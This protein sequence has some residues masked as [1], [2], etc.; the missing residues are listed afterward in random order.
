MNSPPPG[1]DDTFSFRV[2]WLH[3]TMG[4]VAVQSVRSLAAV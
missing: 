2:A 3:A 1:T 4:N